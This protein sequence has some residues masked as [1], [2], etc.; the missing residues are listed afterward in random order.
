MKCDRP[1][2][3]AEDTIKYFILSDQYHHLRGTSQSEKL[4]GSLHLS[5]E[6]DDGRPPVQDALNMSLFV[7]PIMA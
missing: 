5:A 4:G 7:C 2:K 6:G 1:Q 3:A